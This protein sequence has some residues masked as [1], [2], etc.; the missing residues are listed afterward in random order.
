MQAIWA[1]DRQNEEEKCLQDVFSAMFRQF[2]TLLHRSPGHQGSGE[3]SYNVKETHQESQNARHDVLITVQTKGDKSNERDVGAVDWKGAR[4]LER[5]RWQMEHTSSSSYQ[6]KATANCHKLFVEKGGN[7]DVVFKCLGRAMRCCNQFQ[8]VDDCVYTFL[9]Q[10]DDHL[11]F[12]YRSHSLLWSPGHL[13]LVEGKDHHFRLLC[14]SFQLHLSGSRENEEEASLP[15]PFLESRERVRKCIQEERLFA[16]KK[17][18][19]QKNE[20]ADCLKVLWDQ[21]LPSCLRS[22]PPESLAFLNSLANLFNYWY[23]FHL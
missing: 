22:L 14:F 8:F 17:T 20:L 21:C 2:M 10:Q 9:D 18:K 4:M 16:G 5:V 1:A 7:R 12:P 19:K 6:E 3:F 23:E 15:G 13:Y 11:S